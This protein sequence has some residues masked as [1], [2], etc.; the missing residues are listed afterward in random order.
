MPQ[1]LRDLDERADAELAMIT[2][3][4]RGMVVVFEVLVFRF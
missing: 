2:V 1:D 3:S 4:A